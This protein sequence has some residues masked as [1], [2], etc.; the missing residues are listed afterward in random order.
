MHTHIYVKYNKESKIIRNGV[1][2]ALHPQ[3]LTFRFKKFWCNDS[4]R[5]QWV[6]LLCFWTTCVITIPRVRTEP[7]AS[8]PTYLASTVSVQ[9]KAS[10]S[11]ACRPGGASTGAL[12]GLL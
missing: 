8:C 11:S 6:P 5:K 7:A 1:L 3:V 9:T 10:H 4:F 2:S 12:A